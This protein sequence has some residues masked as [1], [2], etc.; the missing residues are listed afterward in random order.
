MR[1]YN[2]LEELYEEVPKEILP[3]EYGGQGGKL[4]DLIADCKTKLEKYRDWFLED[5]NYG[6]DESKR[7]GKPKSA[8][9]VFGL[10]GSFR[11]LSVD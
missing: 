9:S 1:V 6:T 5:Q 3:E 8:E 4:D 7:P 11:Q 2:N 10:E